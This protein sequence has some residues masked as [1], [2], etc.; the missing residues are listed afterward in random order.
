M[1]A[2]KM[3]TTLVQDPY[4]PTGQPVEEA[5]WRCLTGDTDRARPAPPELG[6]HCR[7]WERFLRSKLD[8]AALQASED[9]EETAALLLHDDTNTVPSIE[10]L[11]AL[12]LE[13]E[14]LRVALMWNT[15]R[16]KGC[17]GRAFAVTQSGYMAL[18]PPGTV[19]GDA[20]C[21]LYGVDT[22]FIVRMLS[23]EDASKGGDMKIVSGPEE[24]IEIV[25]LVGE[26]YVHGVMDGEAMHNSAQSQMFHIV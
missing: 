9:R 16:A 6:L 2:R 25:S 13:N 19:A 11:R 24:G 8:A 22:P 12:G 7:L 18:V 14:A 23:I 17:A 1:S 3:A 20:V 10:Q 21:L 15:T 4:P 5:F 26:S